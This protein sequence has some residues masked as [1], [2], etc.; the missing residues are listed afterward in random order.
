MD[1]AAGHSKL[2]DSQLTLLDQ[3][4]RSHRIFL[5]HLY[6]SVPFISLLIGFL[7]YIQIAW[8]LLYMIWI[9][10]IALLI[11]LLARRNQ[12]KEFLSFLFWGGK[13]LK[14]D[15]EKR[16]IS[17]TIYLTR[18]YRAIHIP[19]LGQPERTIETR[20]GLALALNEEIKRRKFKFSISLTLLGL[21]I[22]S[23]LLY[24]SRE[25]D[26]EVV[27]LLLALIVISIVTFVVHSYFWLKWIKIVQKWVN[28]Y[29]AVCEWGIKLEKA[30]AIPNNPED[31]QK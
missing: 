14:S 10:V 19:Y 23:F 11:P 3:V 13:Y 27:P 28:A 21:L 24:L 6:T 17:I 12:I 22:F 16:P 4:R 25:S 15:G 20:E 2:Q 26:P 1:N 29:R 5:L 9:W 31:I 8:N 18:L 7:I 30:F